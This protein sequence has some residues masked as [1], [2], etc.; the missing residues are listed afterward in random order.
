M[1]IPT[2]SIGVNMSFPK[3]PPDSEPRK[4]RKGTFPI[5]VA[6]ALALLILEVGVLAIIKAGG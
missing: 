5:W 6:I 2:R 4:L 1:R 3:L